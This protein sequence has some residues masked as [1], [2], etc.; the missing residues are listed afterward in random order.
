[1]FEAGKTANF[2]CRHCRARF[3]E[4]L[5]STRV[6]SFSSGSRQHATHENFPDTKNANNVPISPS[7]RTSLKNEAIFYPLGKIR[8]S[9]GKSVREK[10]ANLETQSLG[11]PS[12][13]I[14][15]HDVTNDNQEKV[16]ELLINEAKSHRI[17]D[18]KEIVASIEAE[19][20]QLGLDDAVSEIDGLRPRTNL[21]QK[22]FEEMRNQLR[23]GYTIPQLRRYIAVKAPEISKRKVLS[24]RNIERNNILN[25][26]IDVKGVRSLWLA[27]TKPIEQRL[28]LK[29]TARARLLA[30]K[31]SS[32][33]KLADLV[34]LGSW[35]VE[36]EDD[37]EAFG[38][39][40]MKL[41]PWQTNLLLSGGKRCVL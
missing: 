22:A 15:L 13:V 17:L 38:Q 26:S 27:D 32:K 35:K 36:I 9:P 18:S 24:E 7:R 16:P 21:S 25:P 33:T 4:Q 3:R 10:S 28:P 1:M 34:I 19:K 23:D 12:E 20:L 14:I 6:S 41:R 37:I 30:Y 31:R 11:R 8:G 2:I 39:I 29:D 5:R 40:E